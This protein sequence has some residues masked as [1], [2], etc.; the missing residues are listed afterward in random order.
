MPPRCG[1]P[2]LGAALHLLAGTGSAK[3]K[4]GGRLALLCQLPC[5]PPF[6]H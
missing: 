5:Q 6:S 1:L 3:L 2:L 4:N